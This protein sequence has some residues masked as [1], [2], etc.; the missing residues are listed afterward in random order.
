MRGSWRSGRHFNIKTV[1]PGIVISHYKNNT[2]VRSPYFYNGDFSIGKMA[3]A[4]WH[5][6]E[7]LEWSNDGL[8]WISLPRDDVF[9]WKHFPC[10]ISRGG[11]CNYFLD[12]NPPYISDLFGIS[13]AKV[14]QYVMGEVVSVLVDLISNSYM[15]INLDF[16]KQYSS[17]LCHS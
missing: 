9:K 5:G 16:I 1:S 17:S 6:T 15:Y 8:A 3:S 2:V 12:F 4:Y 14:A 10:R 13:F 11:D 7:D